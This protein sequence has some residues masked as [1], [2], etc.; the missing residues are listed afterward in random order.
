MLLLG[1]LLALP[2]AASADERITA[3]APNR[4]TTPNPS[5][6]QGE[7][8]T[9][10]NL[11]ATSHDVVAKQK[12][13]DNRPLFS[14]P[15]INNGAE[16]FVEGS[17]Y[18]TTGAYE[19]FCSIHANMVG[20]LEVSGA[21]TP[22]PRPG[23]GSQPPPDVPPGPDTRAPSVRVA[24]PAARLAA[25]RRSRSLTVS[26]TLDE[27]ARVEL[28]ATARV[29]RRTVALARGSLDPSSA[30]TAR[31]ALRVSGAGARALRRAS[32]LKVTVS[33]K[34]EDAAGN[35]ATAATSRT[36]RR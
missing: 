17:Q 10:Q 15:L 16:V 27:T 7:R 8:L 3:T 2:A 11:D 28:A 32:R 33:A 4:Y 36:L 22:V 31:A 35:A 30:R 5:M 6:D 13:A 21:G 24:L 18:L 29:G 26:V 1:L 23:G 19:F 34:A 25:V 20:R 12:G 9:F 14:T